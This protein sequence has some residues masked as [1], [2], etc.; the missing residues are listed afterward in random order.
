MNLSSISYGS[1]KDVQ[2]YYIKTNN[3]NCYG[4]RLKA[5]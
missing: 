1:I 5:K 4:Y 2:N 3:P